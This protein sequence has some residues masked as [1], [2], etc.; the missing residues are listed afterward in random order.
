VLVRERGGHRAPI[1]APSTQVPDYPPEPS[2]SYVRARPRSRRWLCS[3]ADARRVVE[4]S[5]SLNVEDDP[6]QSLASKLVRLFGE[7]VAIKREL[8]DKLRTG[9][10]LGDLVPAEVDEE[11]EV[12]L[13]RRGA[14][15]PDADEIGT[16]PK[17]STG[18]VRPIGYSTG[19]A[20][21]F[22]VDSDVRTDPANCGMCGNA[23]GQGRSRDGFR[24]GVALLFL[25]ALAIGGAAGGYLRWRGT[26]G[27]AAPVPSPC[28]PRACTEVRRAEA[29]RLRDDQH[30]QRPGER[31]GDRRRRRAR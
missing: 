11:V 8:L 26:D 29:A 10:T 5:R 3:A 27:N 24:W 28:A 30:R 17:R 16:D 22:K 13:V 1:P 12:P 20:E 21:A 14:Y 7:R 9:G 15:I 2:R 31:E 23:A 25:L 6:A 4:V 18:P 19:P